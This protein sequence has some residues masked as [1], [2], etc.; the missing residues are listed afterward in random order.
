MKIEKLKRIL[1]DT[2][3]RLNEAAQDLQKIEIVCNCKNEKLEDLECYLN[4]QIKQSREDIEYYRE[5]ELPVSKIEQEGYR[6][7]LIEIQEWVNEY[8]N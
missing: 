7:A 5:T 8:E 6:R 4:M 1:Y 3:S 2:S